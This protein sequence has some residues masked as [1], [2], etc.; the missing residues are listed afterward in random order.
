[1]PKLCTMTMLVLA[2]LCAGAA[3]ADEN[4]PQ[5]RGPNFTGYVETSGLPVS[6]SETENIVWKTALPSWSGSTPAIWGDRIFLTSPSQGDEGGPGA[7]ATR[8]SVGEQILLLCLDKGNG[9]ILWQ[10]HLDTGNENIGKQNDSSPSPMT[11]GKHVWVMTGTGIVTAFDMDGEALWR[12]NIQEE[13]GDFGHQFGYGASPLLHG[14]MLIIP[15]LHGYH[16]EDP[17]YLVALDGLSGES[18]W[19]VERSTDAELESPDAYTTPVPLTSEGETVVVVS[20]G[21]Y[22]TGHDPATGEEVWRSGGL[23]PRGIDRNRTIVSPVACRGMVFAGPRS[24]EPM[25][26]LR[27]GG[28]G[29]VSMSHLAWKREERH[30]P[31]VPTPACDGTYLYLANDRGMATCLDAETGD[32]VWGPERTERGIVSASPLVADGKV[33]ITNE[34]AVT[35]VIAAGPEFKVLATN[36]LDPAYTLSSIAVSG[37]RLYLRTATHL[38][39]IGE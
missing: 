31:D 33:Y 36:K 18:R 21:D 34:E 4:W 25:L 3:W 7:D 20:G 29:D 39:C 27:G 13:Y 8:P 38:Y 15:V 16:T 17:S 32:V 28:S 2:M 11:D 19:R 14:D 35:T 26:A 37:S 10:R 30:G 24:S 6:W 5:W 1:M 12:R 9:A 22:V 23:N